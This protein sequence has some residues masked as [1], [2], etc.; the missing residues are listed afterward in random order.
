M[1]S[2]LR[3]ALWFNRIPDSRPFR[4]CR[5]LR[6]IPYS[7]IKDIQH[8]AF[9]DGTL[10]AALTFIIRFG[11]ETMCA[12]RLPWPARLSAYRYPE[13]VNYFVPQKALA[14]MEV[15]ALGWGRLAGRIHFKNPFSVLFRTLYTTADAKPWR[16]A[17]NR[18]LFTGP[19]SP[20]C[21]A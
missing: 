11:T 19:T 15:T 9:L 8:G 10:T 14:Q 5:P 4:F 2:A 3:P 13:Y 7:R 21:R 12:P 16:A 17:R 1:R 18:Q 6:Y 20:F